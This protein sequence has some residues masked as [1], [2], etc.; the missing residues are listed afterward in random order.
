MSCLLCVWGCLGG[1]GTSGS[2]PSSVSDGTS[3]LID[4]TGDR[5]YQSNSSNNGGSALFI[6]DGVI[7]EESDANHDDE[8]DDGVLVNIPVIPQITPA[9][10]SY[11]LG[12]VLYEIATGQVPY[13]H[14]RHL[15][16][17]EMAMG[18]QRSATMHDIQ[19]NHFRP[20]LPSHLHHGFATLIQQLWH[21]TP[22]IRPTAAEAATRL[23]DM[24]LELPRDE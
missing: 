14:S 24:I 17:R 23:H 1:T 12:M 10:D 3:I 16:M 5:K 8:D 7:M 15:T 22:T 6:S 21:P 2:Q 18:M 19:M 4:N 13:E 20:P 11:G 9:S